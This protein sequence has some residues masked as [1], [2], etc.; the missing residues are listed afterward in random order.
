MML[1]LFWCPSGHLLRLG[2][3]PNQESTPYPPKRIQEQPTHEPRQPKIQ[4]K[5]VKRRV[6]HLP[7]VIDSINGPSY[8]KPQRQDR[9][10]YLACQRKAL[11][12]TQ[13][14]DEIVV[15]R[16]KQRTIFCR[17]SKRGKY[18]EQPPKT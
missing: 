15:L 1:P 14:L 16:R 2:K 17:R 7:Q 3:Q 18:P 9:V 12:E 8:K 13:P 5:V 4:S 10:D 6:L 11:P